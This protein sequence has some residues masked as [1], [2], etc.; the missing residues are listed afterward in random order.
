[1]KLFVAN[2]A[3]ECSEEKLKECFLEHGEV[4]SCKIVM[5]RETGRSRGFGFVEMGSND[6]GDLAIK[7]LNEKEVLGRPLSV[8]KAREQKR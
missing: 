6:S 3:R 2:I 7:N 1:M 4:K 8:S 5:D